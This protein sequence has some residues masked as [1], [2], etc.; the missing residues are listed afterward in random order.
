M[1]HRLVVTVSLVAVIL[2]LA[3][4]ILAIERL[5]E[6][7]VWTTQLALAGAVAFLIA[8]A[9]IALAVLERG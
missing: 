8:A 6:D 5:A 2:A 4:A 9:A 7:R 3:V 1:A